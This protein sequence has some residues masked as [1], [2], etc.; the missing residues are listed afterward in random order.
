M[1][2]GRLHFL[3]NLKMRNKMCKLGSIQLHLLVSLKENL[4]PLA[5]TPVFYTKKKT[6]FLFIIIYCKNFEKLKE[7]I[8]NKQV[9]FLDFFKQKRKKT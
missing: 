2:D 8:F 4:K 1:V 7:L 3:T 5:F 9:S 6:F